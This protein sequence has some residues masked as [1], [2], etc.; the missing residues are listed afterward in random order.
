MNKM[1]CRDKSAM[2]YDY[3]LQDRLDNINEYIRQSIA[4]QN[5]RK[6]IKPLKIQYKSYDSNTLKVEN[7]QP[8]W[9]TKD[10]PPRCATPYEEYR[11]KKCNQPIEKIVTNAITRQRTCSLYDQIIKIKNSRAR[12]YIISNMNDL[13]NL[14]YSLLIN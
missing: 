12:S 8:S 2:R 7:Y 11:R 5:K 14:G 9:V 6:N 10:P 13:G 1:K 3:T 4:D